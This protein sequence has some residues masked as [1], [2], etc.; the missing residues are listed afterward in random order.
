[1]TGPRGAA[2]LVEPGTVTDTT[3]DAAW[4]PVRVSARMAEP[5]VSFAQHP[6][7]LDGPA[8]Y[9]AYT[10]ATEAGAEL[11]ALSARWAVD[12]VM[13]VAAW[14]APPS[15]ADV[16]ARLLAADGVAVWGW[17]CSRAVYDI[18]VDSVAQVRRRP[19]VR[20]M[21]RYAPD[22]KHHAGLG[23]MKARDTVYPATF[24]REVTWFALADPDGLLALLRR[25]THL[26]AGRAAGNGRVLGW[27]VESDES[28]GVRWRERPLPDVHG[29]PAAI[30]APCW[31]PSRRMPCRG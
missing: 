15:R 26:G 2:L 20:E 4:T 1:M 28:A 9:G 31:H 11:P 16:D 24:S 22:R 3:G 25:V 30:R 18:D 29:V 17:A 14:C 7:A 21:A 8:Q 19:A 27:R 6:G 12:F 13:P 10:A 5:V 23:P